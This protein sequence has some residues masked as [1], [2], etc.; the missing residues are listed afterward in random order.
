MS[1]FQEPWLKL[2]NWNLSVH[3]VIHG[4]RGL[5]RIPFPLLSWVVSPVTPAAAFCL[6]GPYLQLTELRHYCFV[7]VVQVKI[8]RTLHKGRQKSIL[9]TGQETECRTAIHLS[10]MLYYSI[11][12][13]RAHYASLVQFPFKAHNTCRILPSPSDWSFW[14]RTKMALWAPVSPTWM[15]LL[16]SASATLSVW[17]KDSF[18]YFFK[19]S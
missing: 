18:Y 3:M 9:K 11:C 5:C 17:R 15:L 14:L 2:I 19:V 7:V 8:P 1:L 6:Q 16:F 13:E 12:I 10:F 4:E